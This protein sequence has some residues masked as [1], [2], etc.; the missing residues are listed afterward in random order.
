MMIDIGEYKLFMMKA[1]HGKPPVVLEAGAGDDDKTPDGAH[2]GGRVPRQ[3]L[4]RRDPDD[5]GRPP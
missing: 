4:H 2:G 1:G 5:H 3:L